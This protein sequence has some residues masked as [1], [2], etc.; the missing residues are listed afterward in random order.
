MKKTDLMKALVTLTIVA[1]ALMTGCNDGG[2]SGKVLAVTLQEAVSDGNNNNTMTISL[3]DN[4][5]LQLTPYVLPRDATNR[6]VTYSSLHPE[7][8]TV[9]ESGLITPTGVGTDTL[10]VSATD[11]SGVKTSYLV[12]IIDHKVKATAINVTAEGSNMTLKIEGTPFNLAATLTLAPA[13]T[14]DKTLK[15]TSGD[16]SIV[17]VSKEGLVTPVAAGV[18]TVTVET[19]D[20]S[21]LSRVCNVTVL[22]RAPTALNRAGWTAKT[23]AAIESAAGGFSYTPEGIS[24]IPDRIADGG[25]ANALLTGKPEHL[26]DD[27]ADTFLAM[28]KPGKSGYSTGPGA[29]WN[30]DQGATKQLVAL[31]GAADRASATVEASAVN[32]FVVDMQSPQPFSYIRWTHRNATRGLQVWAIDIYGSNDGTTWSG[33][34]NGNAPLEP[35]GAAGEKMIWITADKEEFTY[36]Y[37]KVTVAGYD[38]VNSSNLHVG[39]FGLGRL[40]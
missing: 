8:L 32:Y 4:E 37:V 34:L 28:L 25:V 40:D 17:K 6:N 23:A 30:A 26:F 20:G 2:D 18:T 9:S 29:G 24:W 3:K 7:V 38:T 15:Y 21:N 22:D 12:R 36:R 16:E 33:K 5:T 35:D 27:R 11:G 1:T 14:W 31:L 13:D 39:E 19:T 10:T